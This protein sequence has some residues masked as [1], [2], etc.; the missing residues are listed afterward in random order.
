MCV[1]LS[2]EDC[3]PGANDPCV[4]KPVQGTCSA[5][6]TKPQET[7]PLPVST[8]KARRVLRCRVR[9]DDEDPASFWKPLPLSKLHCPA[10]SRR[11]SYSCMWHFPQSE[12]QL[13]SPQILGIWLQLQ[14]V[15]R[16]HAMPVGSLRNGTVACVSAVSCA[17]WDCEII[18]NKQKAV[19]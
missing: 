5:L 18:E 13:A 14:P 19:G 9:W 12:P 7:V 15:L 3:G 17:C 4:E 6:V 1:S 10:P 16:E 11:H 2:Q 8:G